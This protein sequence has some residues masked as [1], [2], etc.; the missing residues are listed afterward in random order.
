MSNDTTLIS[1]ITNV[2]PSQHYFPAEIYQ[3][4]VNFF[5]CTLVNN[6]FEV[7]IVHLFMC[8]RRGHYSI[9]HEGVYEI[10]VLVS[11]KKKKTSKI[12]NLTCATTSI[13]TFFLSLPFSFSWPLCWLIYICLLHK[14][15]L[16]YD[17]YAQHINLYNHFLK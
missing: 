10:L 13:I 9:I 14:F 8:C 12:I 16:F 5:G 2:D 11:F 4:R 17:T 6:I 15:L 1:Q 3:T 7:V